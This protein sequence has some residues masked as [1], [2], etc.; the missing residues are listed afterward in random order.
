VSRRAVYN[1]TE[2][3]GGLPE[4]P[5]LAEKEQD[6]AWQEM[7]AIN[8]AFQLQKQGGIKHHAAEFVALACRESANHADTTRVLE[9][10]LVTSEFFA[11][12]GR[13][14]CKDA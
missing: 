1:T 12:E 10:L 3:L 9:N 13:T 4:R 14:F 5:V 11:R 8:L 2:W 6:K 7:V